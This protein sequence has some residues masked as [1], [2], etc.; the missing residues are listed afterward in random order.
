[1]QYDWNIDVDIEQRKLNHKMSVNVAPPLTILTRA[2][3]DI[4]KTNF[5]WKKFTIYYENEKGMERI[6]ERNYW[7]LNLK[8]SCFRFSPFTRSHGYTID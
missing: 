4:I 3:L 6:F 1:M 5:E 8:K 2:Y 7:Y